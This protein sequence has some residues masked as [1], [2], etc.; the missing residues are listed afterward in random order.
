LKIAQ[1]CPYDIARPGGVQ[2]HIRD[3]SAE[4]IRRGHEVTIIAPNVGGNAKEKFLSGRLGTCPVAYIGS[5][6]LIKFNE[7]QIE[8]A[9][10]FG[11]ARRRLKGLL[12][13]FDIVHFHTLIS[14]FLPIQALRASRCANVASFHNVPPET[15]TGAIQRYLQR[16]FVRSLMRKLDQIILASEVQK[17]LYAM[18]DPSPF[19]VI[20]PCTDLSRF[21]VPG[22]SFARYRDGRLNILFCGRLEHRKGA[23]ILVLAFHELCRRGLP[24]RLIF[25]GDG[26]ERSHIDRIIKARAIPDVVFMGAVADADIP[27]LYASC[28]IFCAPS[29][30]GEG[31]GIVITE[32]MASGK[33]VVAAANAGYRQLLHGDAARFLVPPGDVEATYRNLETLISDPD[34]RHRLGEWGRQEA[35]RYDSKALCSQFLAVYEE[36]ARSKRSRDRI[37]TQGIP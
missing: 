5:G 4:L 12:Q 19:P 32:A 24:V 30:Y 9:A 21:E 2:H 33:P 16:A 35:K 18:R 28:D 17:T 29:L 3:L 14:P 27:R 13:G 11:D 25:A 23:T 34:L 31:F 15:T 36:A 26:P 22:E 37:E 1:L 20:P 6:R 7:T 8:I 10:A